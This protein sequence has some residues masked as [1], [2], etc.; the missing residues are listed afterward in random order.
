MTNFRICAK[1]KLSYIIYKLG[2]NMN[3]LIM[4]TDDDIHIGNL[5]EE[6]LTSNGYEVARA[7][8][9]T[10]TLMLLNSIKPDLILLDLM[11]PG[12]NGENLLPMIKDIPV[13]VVSAKTDIN[14]KV[15][16]LLSGAA[17]YITK[18]FD[19]N[20]LLARIKVV[21]RSKINAASSDEL[22]FENIR[23]DCHTHIV[24]VNNIEV[25]L[26]KTE[27]A[28]L[29]L[30][31]LNQ[32]QVIAK[33]VILDKIS[34]DTPDCMENSLKVHVSNIRRKLKIR[35]RKRLHRSSLGNWIKLRKS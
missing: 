1:I 9:G 10:E 31:M 17:D 19:I 35:N 29:K 32:S 6:V 25:H 33:S 34:E 16:L 13:I 28:I 12:I 26:T 2:E 23:L 27:Y 30:L 8:S 7:Y 5:L 18:P 14:S 24:S 21:L 15:D 11:I 20:E 3:S 4:I 22:V